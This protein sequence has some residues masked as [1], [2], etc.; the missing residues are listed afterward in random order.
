MERE[1]QKRLH[2][3]VDNK[4]K[5]KEVRKEKNGKLVCLICPHYPQLD[6]IEMFIAH[7]KGKKHKEALNQQQKKTCHNNAASKQKVRKMCLQKIIANST[8]V[9]Q[10]ML[11]VPSNL[12]PDLKDKYNYYNQQLISLRQKG[13]ILYVQFSRKSQT[14]M[15]K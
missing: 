6:T 7:R 13:W 15:R 14:L 10:H 5:L 4:I 3:L 9:Q 8:D 12:E 11:P 1:R 2:D